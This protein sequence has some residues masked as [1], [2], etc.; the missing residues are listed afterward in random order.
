MQSYF[1]FKSSLHLWIWKNGRISNIW[2]ENFDIS[3]FCEGP[4]FQLPTIK[5]LRD[6]R[7]KCE[8]LNV[9]FYLFAFLKEG[10]DCGGKLIYLYSIS[11]SA[12]HILQVNNIQPLH[13]LVYS[14]DDP[15]Q[16]FTVSSV[17]L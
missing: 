3:D 16:V 5:H 4:A 1:Q 11:G 8:Y 2:R 9:F 6:L 13:H 14:P 10:T 15:C 12:D 7:V 17:C